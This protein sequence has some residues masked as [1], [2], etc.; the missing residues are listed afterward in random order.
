M[1]PYQALDPMGVG[2]RGG[3]VSRWRMFTHAVDITGLLGVAEKVRVPAL[4]PTLSL[5]ILKSG[6]P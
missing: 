4:P 5:Q 2:A 3:P 6:P 1:S